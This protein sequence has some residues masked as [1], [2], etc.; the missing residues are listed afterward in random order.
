MKHLAT[1]TPSAVHEAH[2][3][4]QFAR[5]KLQTCHDSLP[6]R[7]HLPLPSQRVV[8][9]LAALL[10]LGQWPDST[11]TGGSVSCPA[12]AAETTADTSG[13]TDPAA[14]V[15]AAGAAAAFAPQG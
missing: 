7:L 5:S 3:F 10:H 8:H 13:C 4:E 12:A 1:M 2:L 11:M 9:P 14:I 15:A 6:S